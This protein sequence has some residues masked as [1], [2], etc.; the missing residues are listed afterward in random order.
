M[1]LYISNLF[2]KFID[3][4]D[5]FG[6]LKCWSCWIV[7]FNKSKLS[8]SLGQ[9]LFQ[10]LKLLG[11]WEC[12]FAWKLVNFGK[13]AEFV[14]KKQISQNLILTFLSSF[15]I[16]NFLFPAC[17]EFISCFFLIIIFRVKNL[18]GSSF[19][20]PFN[21]SFFLICQLFTLWLF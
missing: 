2:A 5:R 3:C 1:K 12:W 17:H 20:F 16:I 21:F 7:S 15:Q 11:I 6:L 8:F 4:F 18:S 9:W 19:F 14:I 10:S 13:F